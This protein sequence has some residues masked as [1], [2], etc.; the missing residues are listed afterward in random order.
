MRKVKLFIACSLDG[1][2]ATPEGGVDFLSTVEQPGEDYGYAAF[3]ETID[4]VV[5]GRKTYEKVLSFGEPFPHRCPVY[6][7]AS[8]NQPTANNVHFYTNGPVNLIHELLL[9]PGKDI[10]VDGGAQVVHALLQQKLIHELTVSFIPVLLGDGIRLF[11][12]GFDSVSLSLQHSR[13]FPSGLVQV[14]YSVR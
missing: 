1:Y 14:T 13:S 11:Q 6:V 2:I 9:Q 10:F 7:I 3:Y 12:E 5:L 4:T 8:Q